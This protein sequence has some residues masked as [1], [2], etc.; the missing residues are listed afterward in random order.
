M[1]IILVVIFLAAGILAGAFMPDEW[2]DM[3]RRQTC[4]EAQKRVAEYCPVKT[5]VMPAPEKQ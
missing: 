1:Q 3:I 2:R 4:D 5:P